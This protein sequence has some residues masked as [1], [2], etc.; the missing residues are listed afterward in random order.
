LRGVKTFKKEKERRKPQKD[1]GKRRSLRETWLVKKVKVG[2]PLR[3]RGNITSTG[4]EGLLW[5]K[6]V[7]REKL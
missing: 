1:R 7:L 5:E 3:E 4:K 2:E 6:A